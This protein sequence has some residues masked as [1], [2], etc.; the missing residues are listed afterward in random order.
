MTSALKSTFN[1]VEIGQ[2]ELADERARAAEARALE[3]PAEREADQRSA[4]DE[5][6]RTDRRLIDHNRRASGAHA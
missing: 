1:T 2:V 5:R 4:T 6:C 3:Q